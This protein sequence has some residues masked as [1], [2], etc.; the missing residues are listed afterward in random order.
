MKK[1]I[2]SKRHVGD[3]RFKADKALKEANM[4]YEKEKEENIYEA[5]KQA[6]IN[7]F[8]RLFKILDGNPD[9]VAFVE[10]SLNENIEEENNN[11]KCYDN[12]LFISYVSNAKNKN[13]YVTGFNVDKETLVESK[14]YI[15]HL[16]SCTTNIE[17]YHTSGYSGT[18]DSSGNISI[19]RDS[20]SSLEYYLITEEKMGTI[21][22]SLNYKFVKANKMQEAINKENEYAPQFK[23]HSNYLLYKNN[24]KNPVTKSA[25]TT[26]NSFLVLT[27]IFALL[28]SVYAA[29][30]VLFSYLRIYNVGNTNVYLDLKRV[31][32]SV[33]F[34]VPFLSALLV[35]LVGLIVYFVYAKKYKYL[36]QIM[37]SQKSMR[38]IQFGTDY[39]TGFRWEDGAMKVYCILTF[40]GL[41][42]NTISILLSSI[43]SVA[44]SIIASVFTLFCL[45][46]SLLMTFICKYAY[47][48]YNN[49]NDFMVHM[50]KFSDSGQSKE[51]DNL[52]QEIKSFTVNVNL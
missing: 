31:N 45:V 49:W 9:L 32:L 34:L 39:S 8:D 4:Q 3:S 1:N 42:V 15:Y 7:L 44:S 33:W 23:L 20:S 2:V 37:T 18:V 22:R 51:C 10:P 41:A 21:G 6:N 30:S 26:F 28:F 5:A 11:I 48:D 24:I 27:V 35:H 25:C 19:S 16:A 29:I 12:E 50:N 38:G 17:S 46:G 13:V 14:D 43:N 47:I 36:K 40:V 52:V